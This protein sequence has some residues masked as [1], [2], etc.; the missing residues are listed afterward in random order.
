M[1][2]AAGAG[3]VVAV[4][5][6]FEPKEKPFDM[7]LGAGAIGTGRE[8]GLKPKAD[9]CMLTPAL[10][11]TI[12]AKSNPCRLAVIAAHL[13]VYGASSLSTLQLMICV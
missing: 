11:S 10:P 12:S 8:V 9:P 7:G 13:R 4:L 3:G 2:F 5:E 6:G 1:A